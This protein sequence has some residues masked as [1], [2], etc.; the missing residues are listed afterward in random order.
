MTNWL[1]YT[2]ITVIAMTVIAALALGR[3]GCGRWWQQMVTETEE[4]D[5][6]SCPCGRRSF[7][8]WEDMH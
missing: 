2:L 8:R 6:I 3:C 4:G 1:I 5:V 7:I